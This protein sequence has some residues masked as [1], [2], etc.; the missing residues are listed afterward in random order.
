[1]W[2]VTT[3]PDRPH[4]PNRA[5]TL[6]AVAACAVFTTIGAALGGADEPIWTGGWHWEA[7]KFTALDGTVTLF[8]AVWPLGS[9][10]RHLSQRHRWASPA[11]A[12]S[13]SGAFMPQ[14]LALIAIAVALR[15]LPI[16]AELKA[17]IIAGRGHRG[18]V[19]AGVAAHHPAYPA[20]PTRGSATARGSTADDPPTSQAEQERD[21]QA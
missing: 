4:R 19:R 1:M 16:A 8:A 6:A 17:L 14:G 5:T 20:S 11:I 10:Q 13:A 15:P 18:I 9:T 3:I 12:R 7:L 21:N 2:P